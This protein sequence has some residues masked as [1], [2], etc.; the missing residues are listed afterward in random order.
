MNQNISPIKNDDVPLS[1]WFLRG[2]IFGASTK[3]QHQYP[4]SSVM[5][6]SVGG[7]FVHPSYPPLLAGELL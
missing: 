1:C 7:F 2:Y 4:M 6:L 3:V 5:R